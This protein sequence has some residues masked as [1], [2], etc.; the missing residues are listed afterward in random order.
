MK[1]ITVKK[2]E[3][4]RICSTKGKNEKHKQHFEDLDV[5]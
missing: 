4:S 5:S 3:M 2:D 1:V